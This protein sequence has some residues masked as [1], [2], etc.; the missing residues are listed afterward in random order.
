MKLTT[1][2]LL[3]TLFS[4]VLLMSFTACSSSNKA[5]EQPTEGE[6]QVLKIGASPS[7][8]AEILEYIKPALLEKGIDLQVEVFTDYI[9]PNNAVDGGD[10][11]ANF[12]QHK[13]YLDDF[14]AKNG[15]D[16]VS[17]AAIH[18]EPLGIYPG[19]TASVKD[20][21]D[22]ATI[23]VPNDT[24]NEAR[25]LQLL[26][27]LGLIQIDE[28]AGLEATPANITSN[29]K[30]LE[31]LEVEAAQVPRTLPDVD[32][33]VVNGNYAIAAG[34]NETVLE[35]EAN[36]SEGAQQYAN[37]IAVKAGSENSDKIKAL[38]E[39]LET[40]DVKA[41]MNEKYGVTVVPVF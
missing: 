3:A 22:G 13:P 33:G 8:H 21:K 32:L 4:G 39:A 10:I 41:F 30:N 16:L 5:N 14:N 2:K 36:D 40:D 9:L 23:A 1:K 7:P 34:I 19:K 27:S 12:F 15:T 28:N 35:T 11:D 24:T 29:P 25:A 38:I 20:L 31:I 17:A 6:K 18:F 37:I 26:A